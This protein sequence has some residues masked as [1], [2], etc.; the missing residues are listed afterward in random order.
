MYKKCIWHE[1]LEYKR[2]WAPE[3][4]APAV[5]YIMQLKSS[6][7]STAADVFSCTA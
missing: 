1:V 2:K 7:I 3:S 4:F 5:M 6:L